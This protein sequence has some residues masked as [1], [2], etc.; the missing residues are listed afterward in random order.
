MQACM[1]T[2]CRGTNG[3]QK[4]AKG[5]K[6]EVQAVSKQEEKESLKFY[7]EIGLFCEQ[8]TNLEEQSSKQREENPKAHLK[9]GLDMPL[10]AEQP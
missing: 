3:A 10:L 1:K 9:Q 7:S 2:D 4:A 6:Q 8:S 5:S